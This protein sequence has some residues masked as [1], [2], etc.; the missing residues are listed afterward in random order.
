MESLNVNQNMSLFIPRVF[1]NITKDRILNTME[2]NLL[3]KVKR[4]DLINKIDNSG[5]AYNSAYIHFNYWFNSIIVENFQE[6][7]RNPEKQARI[8]YEDPWYWI[9]LE[10]NNIVNRKKNNYNKSR[11]FQNNI[12]DIELQLNEYK[13]FENTYWE[14]QEN[15]LY[16]ADIDDYDDSDSDSDSGDDAIYRCIDKET[17]NNNSKNNNNNNNNNE[18]KD[19]NTSLVSQD[20]VEFIEQELYDARE[21]E[22]QLLR[23]IDCYKATLTKEYGIRFN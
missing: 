12:K 22:I 17:R 14:N 10:N 8:V 18:N 5:K 16:E 6:R 1:S 23:E 11:T 13:Y 4:V 7:I 2:M 19:E 15:E 21:F 20:Y 3:G 9:I